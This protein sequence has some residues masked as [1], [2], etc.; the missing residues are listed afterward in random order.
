VSRERNFKAGETVISQGDEG[1]GFYLITSGRVEVSRDGTPSA[2][3]AQ[4]TG[5]ASRPCSTT[6]AAAHRQAVED[7]KTLAMMRSDFV[8]ELRSNPDLAIKVLAVMS[9]RLREV[10]DKPTH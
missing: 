8:A 1:V 2:R 9:R 7:T 6:T 4:T 5:S 10:E 3:S